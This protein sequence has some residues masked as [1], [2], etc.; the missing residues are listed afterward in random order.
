ML[1]PG[2]V[3][4]AVM[5]AIEPPLSLFNE[6]VGKLTSVWREEIP[7]FEKLS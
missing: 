1:K 3:F 5:A 7:H 2:G 4:A 6:V